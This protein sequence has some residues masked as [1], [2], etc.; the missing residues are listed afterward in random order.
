[1]IQVSNSVRIVTVA[2]VA[3]CSAVASATTELTIR[4]SAEMSRS[5]V[6]LGD[7]AEVVSDDEAQARQL[8]ALPL[9][10]APAAGGQRFLRKREIEV[11]LA[12]HGVDLR[13]LRINGA[14]QVTIE[15]SPVAVSSR[16]NAIRG[17]A[18]GKFNRHAAL[19]AGSDDAK[20][21]TLTAG[22]IEPDTANVLTNGVRTLISNHLAKQSVDE[23]RCELECDVTERH[24]ALLATAT[25]KPRC[26][27]GAAPWTGRQ[28]FEI[29]FTTPNGAAKFPIY[30]QIT[31]PPMP[32]VVALQPIARGEILTADNVDLRDV[33]YVPKAN[34]RRV[35]IDS[36]DRLIGME[37][38]Q[39]I[40]AGTIVFTDSVQSPVV[41][42]RGE[43][44]TVSSQV[45]GIR[46]RTTAKALQDRSRGDVVQVESL[47]TK[48][49]F[50]ARVIG[51]GKAVIVPITAPTLGKPDQRIETARRN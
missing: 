26:T 32:V 51:P 17:A 13:E 44:I 22:R 4:E 2:A 14:Q 34:E 25:T 50:D 35:A 48:E 40:P 43:L 24:L 30:A 38:R 16:D 18:I 47:Q 11:L 41:V 23:S 29:S 36:I 6:R 7:V 21:A 8:T 37:A 5:V 31:P 12:A 46:V 3:I 45:S 1:M 15:G 42:K 33:G 9:M 20:S 49:K 39:Q 27:G 28:R 19:L 10:P